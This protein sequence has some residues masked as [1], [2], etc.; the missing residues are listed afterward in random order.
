MTNLVKLG[1]PVVVAAGNEA[2]DVSSFSPARVPAAITVGAT[3]IKDSF[4]T[5][6]NFGAG[7]DILAPGVDILAASLNS[8]DGLV[9][10]SGTSQ[11][12]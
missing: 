11:A 6:S 7:V 9:F 12:A 10:R 1:I 2:K 3:D 5:F 8:K 4:A